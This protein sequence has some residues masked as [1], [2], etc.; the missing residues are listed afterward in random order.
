MIKRERTQYSWATILQK[1]MHRPNELLAASPLETRPL[2]FPPDNCWQNIFA[3]HSPTLLKAFVVLL[4]ATHEGCMRIFVSQSI[5]FAKALLECSH[6][7]QYSAVEWKERERKSFFS[8][9]TDDIHSQQLWCQLI[10]SNI[11]PPSRCSGHQLVMELWQLAKM[12]SPHSSYFSSWW[13]A[14]FK[15]VYFLRRERN[16]LA[17]F[18]YHAARLRTFWCT[19]SDMKAF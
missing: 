14:F 6:L 1:S 9:C 17:H 18:G 16:I 4:C 11:P 10:P 3:K 12:S 15:P 19:F 13:C 2:L 5:S 7:Q 8:T